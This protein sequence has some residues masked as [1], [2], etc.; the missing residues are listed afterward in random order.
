MFDKHIT[1]LKAYIKGLPDLMAGAFSKME[2]RASNLLSHLDN[3]NVIKA[4]ESVFVTEGETA[5]VVINT[6]QPI[7]VW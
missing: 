4:S 1:T 2:L 6:T 5:E 7:G 3:V